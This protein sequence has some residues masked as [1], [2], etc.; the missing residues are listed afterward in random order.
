MV[1]DGALELTRGDG[2]NFYNWDSSLQFAAPAQT[3]TT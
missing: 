1:S 2:V 3:H